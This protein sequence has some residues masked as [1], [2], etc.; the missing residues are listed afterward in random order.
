MSKRYTDVPFEVVSGPRRRKELPGWF[1]AGLFGLVTVWLL[2]T[3]LWRA[4][5][6]GDYPSTDLRAPADARAAPQAPPAR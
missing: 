3:L 5:A 6:F 1:K 4:G 2:A